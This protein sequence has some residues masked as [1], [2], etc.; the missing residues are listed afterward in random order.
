M[1][2]PT[3]KAFYSRR[4]GFVELDDDVLSI[5]RQVRDQYGDRVKINW[6]PTTEKYVFVENCADGQERLI[7][8]VDELDGRALERLLKADAEWWGHGDPYDQQE[9]EQDKLHGQLEEQHREGLREGGERLAHALKVD[10]VESSPYPVSI[11]V[12]KDLDG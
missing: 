10:G 3:L 12:K 2:I 8:M 11:P 6:E 9:R 7:F 4:E 5:V 1:E